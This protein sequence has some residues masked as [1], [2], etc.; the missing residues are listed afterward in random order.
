MISYNTKNIW[1]ITFPILISTLIGQI[2]GITDVIFLG[3]VST[4]AIGAAGLGSVYFF[5]LFMII[6]GFSFGAQII[7]S[8]RNGEQNYQKI[9]AVF[10]QG[11]SFLLVFSIA[12]ILLSKFLTNDLLF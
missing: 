10:Y 12:L 5:A 4:V 2:I 8:H 3:H 6:S 1:R 7:M 9:G 11:L